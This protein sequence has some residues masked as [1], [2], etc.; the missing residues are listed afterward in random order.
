MEPCAP[1]GG[2]GSTPRGGISC[3]FLCGAKATDGRR[4]RD[5]RAGPPGDRPRGR[6]RVAPR[7]D[8]PGLRD[9]RP[10]Q[11]R[12]G[13]GGPRS[14]GRARSSTRR[15]GRPGRDRSPSSVRHPGREGLDP[16]I[17]L[18]PILDRL[19]RQIAPRRSPSSRPAGRRRRTIA[20]PAN[21]DEPAAE[22]DEGAGRSGRAARRADRRIDA[23]RGA[24]V[25]G[26]RAVLAG[27]DRDV[28]LGR[29]PEGLVV[30]SRA[31]CLARRTRRPVRLRRPTLEDDAGARRR[32]DR[33][34]APRAGQGLS[35][36]DLGAGGQFPAPYP[37]GRRADRAAPGPLA[38]RP[39]P[40]SDRGRGRPRRA[41]PENGP[42]A[43]GS[44]TSGR[45]GAYARRDAPR[46]EA[47][48]AH[49]SGTRAYPPTS[50]RSKGPGSCCS[51]CR[52]I[53]AR[54]TSA[55]H[56]SAMAGDLRVEEILA[57]DEVLA[58]SRPD[59]R[60]RPGGGREALTCAF[61]TASSGI[62]QRGETKGVFQLESPG[63]R[64]LLIAGPLDCV[65]RLGHTRT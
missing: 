52:P 41:D 46:S 44:S 31:A 6:R 28:A 47:G 22:H 34:A 10:G 25:Q 30:A 40:R 61:S 24:G 59:R 14:P 54:G 18:G 43:Q 15:R 56:F 2:P 17:A 5:R 63:I 13:R 33:R 49:G 38:P 3:G 1:P 27:G 11:S 51:G 29:G 4:L 42:P 20:P 53:C 16:T 48:A 19:D 8:R 55:G 26:P 62:L 65:I 9:P 50:R 23:G 21:G 45:G 37:A 64:D 35:G 36:A 57:A 39:P 32:A 60:G 12:R 58:Y 7:G